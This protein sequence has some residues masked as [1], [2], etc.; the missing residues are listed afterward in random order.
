MLQLQ[1]GPKLPIL[2]STTTEA[3]VSND[4]DGIPTSMRSV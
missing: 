1:V 3:L 2:N 4:K